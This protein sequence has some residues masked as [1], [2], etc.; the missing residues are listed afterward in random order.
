MRLFSSASLLLCSVLLLGGAGCSFLSDE[1]SHNEAAQFTAT[2]NGETWKGDP[3]V[4]LRGD[5]LTVVG[6]QFAEETA[7][8]RA[9]TVSGGPRITERVHLVAPGFDGPGTYALAPNS[10]Y[11]QFV[12][13]DAVTLLASIADEQCADE[14]CR[15]QVTAYDAETG[16][17]Q[18]RFSVVTTTGNRTFDFRNGRFNGTL[19]EEPRPQ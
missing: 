18:G 10:G 17:L 1:A 2:L 12:G 13:G 11:A 9:N 16:T 8:S 14:T 15:L 19:H 4:D 3:E 7:S 6:R 5:T